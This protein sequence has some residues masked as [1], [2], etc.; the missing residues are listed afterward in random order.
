MRVSHLTSGHF[1]FNPSNDSGQ[2]V[3]FAQLH[4]CNAG[5]KL[6]EGCIALGN[7]TQTS[8]ATGVLHCCLLDAAVSILSSTIYH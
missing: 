8:I 6:Y 1:R 3:P 7:K 2:I 5:S 4:N